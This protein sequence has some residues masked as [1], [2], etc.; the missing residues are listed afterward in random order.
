ML[1]V[2]PLELRSQI[3]SYVFSNGDDGLIMLRATQR[4]NWA[5]DMG[6]A[7]YPILLQD[8]RYCHHRRKR[9]TLDTWPDDVEEAF[10]KGDTNPEL[11]VRRLIGY[12][13]ALRWTDTSDV[14]Q[15][16]LTGGNAR[17]NNEL[18][19][20]FICE[21]T[22]QFRDHQRVSSHK[23]A[24]QNITC[25]M[26]EISNHLTRRIVSAAAELR[27]ADMGDTAKINEA[28]GQIQNA[29]Y[30]LARRNLDTE[31]TASAPPRDRRR[32]VRAIPKP[33]ISLNRT[34]LDGPTHSLFHQISCF[35]PQ[36]DREFSLQ[37]LRPLGSNFLALS[38][39][40]RWLRTE[41]LQYIESHLSF[42]FTWDAVAL[43]TFCKHI[44]AIHR[45][46]VQHIAIEYVESR[47]LDVLNP[48]MTLGTYLSDNLPNLR[49]M[50]LTLIPCNPVR[51]L[52]GSDSDEHRWGQQTEDFLS[53]LGGLTAT[54]ILKLQWKRDCDHFERKYVG[55]RGWKR[56]Q[57]SQLVGLSW[58]VYV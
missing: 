19:S 17:Y 53:S 26:P 10:H 47:A 39:V 27:E 48:P 57:S 6:V 3:Y 1:S 35:A 14:Y 16:R 43:Q 56:I 41:I 46:Q 20:T 58:N 5:G 31:P 11:T 25:L 22:G 23:T 13:L 30:I 7:P 33:R 34:L 40:N 9:K 32:Q 50:F 38:T 55:V 8:P 45:R 15:Y 37:L 28:L 42:D 52:W 4:T 44:E 51:R 24:L 36:S 12:R 49:R 21:Y 18:V 2:L 54:V 29:S